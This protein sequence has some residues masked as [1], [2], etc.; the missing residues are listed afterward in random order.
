MMKRFALPMIPLCASL[1]AF[2]TLAGCGEQPEIAELSQE[3]TETKAGLIGQTDFDGYTNAVNLKS[4]TFVIAAGTGTFTPS[5]ELSQVLYGDPNGAAHK[6]SFAVPPI[7]SP[8][9]TIDITKLEADMAST[10]LTLLGSTAAVKL[11]FKGQLKIV[12]T[13][14]IFG[15]RSAESVINPSNLLTTLSYDKATARAKVQSVK[16]NFSVK[17]QKCGGTGWCNGI[18]DGILKTNLAGWV[19]TPLKDALGKA[20]DD[21]DVT[22]SLVDGLTIM[23]NAK[24]PKP[25]QWTMDAASL[26]LSTAAFRFNVSRTTP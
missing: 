5:S 25:T 23:Y 14:P 11:A 15:K 16:A 24:D 9:A 12:A 8:A 2:G 10:G 19:E 18:I 6:S 17:T 1:L 4:C 22:T 3:L 21:A 7:V 13:V 20:L 26:E